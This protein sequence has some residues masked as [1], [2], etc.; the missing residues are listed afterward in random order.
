MMNPEKIPKR[1][2]RKRI[3]GWTMPTGA[4]Y[5]GRPTIFGNP[6]DIQIYGTDLS[7]KLFAKTA[8][9]FW[10]PLLLSDKDEDFYA[11]AYNDHHKWLKRIGRH[12]VET[13]RHHLKGKDLACFCREG[14]SCH[15]D[16]LIE[17]ANE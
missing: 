14:A 2:Q 12:P 15:G 8:R 4:C 5:I 17:I 11:K 9:G 1:I 6:Y 16:T 13:I 7:L 10:D 3:K